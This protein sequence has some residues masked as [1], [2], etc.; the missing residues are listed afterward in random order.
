MVCSYKRWVV[1]LGC[2][3]TQ[4]HSKQRDLAEGQSS[5]NPAPS[6]KSLAF[7]LFQNPGE[8]TTVRLQN[9]LPLCVC[10]FF[11]GGGVLAYVARDYAKIS[12]HKV[13]QSPLSANENT[14]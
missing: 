14:L 6:A 7:I 1:G 8:V 10:V 5:P 12:Q 9:C 3:K 2:G 4:K 11:F 13:P